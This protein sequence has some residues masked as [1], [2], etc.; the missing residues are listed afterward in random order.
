MHTYEF[1]MLV[2]ENHLTFRQLSNSL[3]I[4]TLSDM[5]LTSLLSAISALSTL[6]SLVSGA[7]LSESE[8]HR[9]GPLVHKGVRMVSNKSSRCLSPIYQ[10]R[11]PNNGDPVGLMDCQWSKL[12]DIYQDGSVVM[13]DFNGFAIDAGSKPG[14]G[15][16]LKVSLLI[17]YH[18]HG[19]GFDVG[20]DTPGMDQLPGRLSAD[21]DYDL[22]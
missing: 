12:W 21:L 5:H 7:P 20:A 1:W 6:S 16:R 18:H 19:Y 10:S 9:R 2:V 13:H 3:R 11:Y 14:N 15:V 8:L 22:P 17:W 4:P